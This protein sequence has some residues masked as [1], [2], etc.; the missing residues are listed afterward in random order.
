MKTI[1][2]ESARL[3]GKV[4]TTLMAAFAISIM[5]IVLMVNLHKSSASESLSGVFDKNTDLFRSNSEVEAWM[6]AP[7]AINT[8]AGDILTDSY[9]E[10]EI[11]IEPWMTDPF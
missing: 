2:K 11:L 5:G 9:S 10:D 8:T 1:N 4:L 7:F 6:T 3:N